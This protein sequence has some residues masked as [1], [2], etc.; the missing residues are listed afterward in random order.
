[1]PLSLNNQHP[2]SILFHVHSP[3]ESELF[4]NVPSSEEQLQEATQNSVQKSHSLQGA[5][6]SLA[7]VLG[8]QTVRTS[9]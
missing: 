2:S 5:L 1:M 4:L 6:A 7:L 3:F 8:A 9:H